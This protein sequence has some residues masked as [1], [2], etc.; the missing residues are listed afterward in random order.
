MFLYVRGDACDED[1]DNDGIEN[2]FDNC[3][4]AYN[5]DQ[6]DLNS[7]LNENQLKNCIFLSNFSSIFQMMVL[8]IFVRMTSI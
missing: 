6:L 2:D 1:M 7:E 5:P 8:A 3:P 4:V